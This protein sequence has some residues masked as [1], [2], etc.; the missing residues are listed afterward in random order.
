MLIGFTIIQT[1]E[2]SVIEYK[3]IDALVGQLN[4]NTELAKGRVEIRDIIAWDKSKEQNMGFLFLDTGKCNLT[5]KV[6]N[7]FSFVNTR[8]IT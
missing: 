7:N 5:D 6:V 8:A 2:N 3:K 4:I 1:L